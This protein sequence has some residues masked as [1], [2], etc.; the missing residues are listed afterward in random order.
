M[1]IGEVARRAGIQASAIRYYESVG[2]LP[3]PQRSGGK[4]RYDGT[5]LDWL[6][7]IAIAREAGFTMAELKRLVTGFAPG[8]PPERRWHDLATRKLAEID[9]MVVRARRMRAILRT[10]LACGCFRLEDCGPLL[11][12]QSKAGNVRR[13]HGVPSRQVS[14]PY[15][16][17]SHRRRAITAPDSSGDE[18]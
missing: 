16:R 3:E 15:P 17:G 12:E 4:R 5:A 6:S 13:G 2:L 18:T 8:T 11:E 9:A 14:A 7:L 10:A 1:S